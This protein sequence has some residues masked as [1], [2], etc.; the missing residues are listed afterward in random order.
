MNFEATARGRG[1]VSTVAADPAVVSDALS[2][3]AED[4][5]VLH[6][7]VNAKLSDVDALGSQWAA[8]LSTFG[9]SGGVVVVLVEKNSPDL[10]SA[11]L[12]ESNL[13]SGVSTCNATQ[14]PL[15]VDDF[16]DSV[17]A[18]IP[19]PFSAPEPSIALTYSAAASPTLSIPV[20]D[21]TNAPIV[22]SSRHFADGELK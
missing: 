15:T 1:L 2:R 6:V 5:F 17:T 18:G 13:L 19:S 3:G 16:L 12:D 7:P 9:K 4:V 8:P 21:S 10:V 11:M 14:G 20:V 22:H